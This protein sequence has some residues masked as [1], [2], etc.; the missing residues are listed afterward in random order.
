MR[1]VFFRTDEQQR[2]N[3]ELTTFGCQ[4]EYWAERKLLSVAVPNEKVQAVELFLDNEAS[5]GSLDYEEP[6]IRGQR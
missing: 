6:I 4:T 2:V 1:I 5:L 3:S